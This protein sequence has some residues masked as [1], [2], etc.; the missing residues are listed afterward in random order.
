M[1]RP[2]RT[3]VRQLQPRAVGPQPP[4]LLHLHLL[5][6]QCLQ[7]LPGRLQRKQQSRQQR[8]R[9]PLPPQQQGQGPQQ[10]PPLC[11]CPPLLQLQRW[12]PHQH[13]LC[14][15]PHCLQLWLASFPL[16]A[17]QPHPWPPFLAPWACCR[18][19][20]QPPSSHQPWQLLLAALCSAHQAP[21]H[22]WWCP[23]VLLLHLVRQGQWFLVHL[24]HLRLLQGLQQ[25]WQ[26]V[27]RMLA[28]CLPQQCWQLLLLVPSWLV[29]RWCTPPPRHHLRRQQQHRTRRTAC[30][31][32]AWRAPSSA[33]SSHAAMRWSARTAA[34]RLSRKTTSA[35]SAARR[36]KALWTWSEVLW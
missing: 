6:R 29:P 33:S 5:P 4:T 17:Q 11:P 2:R 24:C 3:K 22:P 1:S 35:R 7:P 19:Q 13:L 25:R 32:C 16:C 9:P 26:R 18:Q 20:L 34:T 27:G 36:C 23:Q 21:S 30:A 28:R 31:A 12:L 10:H 8:Q 14:C 15:H